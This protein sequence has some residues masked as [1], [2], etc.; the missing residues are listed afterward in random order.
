ME[1]KIGLKTFE[2]VYTPTLLT[3]LG[4][5]LYLRLGW[6]VG[7]AGFFATLLIILL[8]HVITFT[9]ALSM[10]SMLTNIKIGSGGAYAIITRS[11]GLEMG[12][13][14]G[15]P[16]YVSQAISVAFYITGFS[17][18]WITFFPDH[19]Q[20]LVGVITWGILSLISLKSAKLAFRIQYVILVA[21]GLS[22]ISFL[23][24]PNLNTQG[25]VMQGAF[26]SAGFWTTFAIF[27]PA[28]TGVLTGATMSGDLENPR[29]SIIKGTLSAILTGLI[30]YIIVAYWFAHQADQETLVS[31]TSIIFELA[32]VEILIIAGVMGAVLSSALSTLVSAPRTLAALAE[33]RVVPFHKTLGKIN[34]AGEPINAIILSSIISLLVILAGN[35]DSLASL[36][37]MFFLTTYGMINLVVF[38]EQFTGIISY[39]PSLKMSIFVPIVGSLGCISVMLLINPIFTV[40]TFAVIAM[41]YALLKNRNFASPYGDVRGG[42]FI[43]ISEWAAQKSASIPYH[44]R[45]W[46]PSVAVPVEKPEDFK[47]LTRIIKKLVY[48]SGRVYYIASHEECPIDHAH[49]HQI[50]EVLRPLRDE[51]IFVQKTTVTSDDFSSVLIPTLQSLKSTYLPPN[52]I[53]LTISEDPQ[54]RD[55]LKEMVN[56]IKP[57]NLSVGCLWLHPK[58]GMGNERKINL[59]L[60]DKSPNNDLAIL[61]ALQLSRNYDAELNL[62]R[63]VYDENEKKSTIQDLVDFIDEARL[64]SNTK[65]RVYTGRFKEL[66]GQNNADINILG[67]PH[68]FSAMTSIIEASPSSILFVASGGLE[69]ALI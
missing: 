55:K 65:V 48:P 49:D 7:N 25:V 58:F 20:L 22:I 3:I 44:P 1:K 28:V 33:N 40:V 31:N 45:L 47:R 10:S 60:R 5:I 30:I 46:K 69:N 4:V 14:I 16:L 15:V 42:I 51:K 61:C 64:P 8:A 26:K 23:T 50:D 29:R 39:R 68:E 34:K 9:T 59:W 36:L 13:A 12:G 6:I 35:L 63:V 66:M 43:S 32:S 27:F 21:V 11:L 17:E 62:C 37:T 18:L 57:L 53:L 41:I 19:S 38:L 24:G 67:M 56:R 54:K 2:G 52:I